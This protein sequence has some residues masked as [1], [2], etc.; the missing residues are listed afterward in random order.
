[1]RRR[2]FIGLVGGAAVS[3]WPVGI[4]AQNAIVPLIGYLNGG[5][6]T[7]NTGIL[8]AF[9]KGLAE[10]GFIEN[11]NVGVE[12]RW[13]E[14]RYETLPA[15]ASEL[16][17][18]NPDVIVAVSAPAALAAKGATS[19]IPIVFTAGADPVRMGLVESLNRPGGNLTGVNT[20]G[21]EVAAKGLG[22]LRD[23]LP[24]AKVIAVHERR[25]SVS[26]HQDWTT[27]PN[28]DCEQ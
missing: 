16:V 4:R 21:G 23:L 17:R 11:K 18:R 9:R 25:Y 15:L 1:M 5:A 12:W 28:P 3:A 8:V 26:G 10:S 6:Q 19:T 14:G 7:S 20:S 2:E 13:A 24:T 27:G 22:V